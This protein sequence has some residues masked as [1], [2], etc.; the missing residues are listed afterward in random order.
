MK[1]NASKIFFVLLAVPRSATLRFADLL[2]FDLQN[3]P[4]RASLSRA[5]LT[6]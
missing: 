6:G 5:Q 3:E 2:M 4:S 1:S